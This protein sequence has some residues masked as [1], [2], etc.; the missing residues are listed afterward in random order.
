LAL[1]SVSVF[2]LEEPLEHLLE[3][4]GESFRLDGLTARDA[5]LILLAGGMLG[6]GGAWISVERHLRHL[7]EDGTLGRR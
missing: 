3:S 6:L 7:R 2:Y 1:L 5:V 4:Y